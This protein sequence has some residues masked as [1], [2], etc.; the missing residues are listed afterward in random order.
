MLNPY[1]KPEKGTLSS[2]SERFLKL[3]VHC[4]EIPSLE[5]YSYTTTSQNC[6]QQSVLQTVTHVITFSTAKLQTLK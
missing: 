6:I 5:Y 2:E 4:K 3:N 1:F